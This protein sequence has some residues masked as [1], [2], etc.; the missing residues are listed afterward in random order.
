MIAAFSHYLSLKKAIWGVEGN[1]SG[2][3]SSSRQMKALV[4]SYRVLLFTTFVTL[5]IAVLL[6]ATNSTSQY[7]ST[8]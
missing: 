3:G 5:A 2:R 8:S 4:W 1:S 7:M 6:F